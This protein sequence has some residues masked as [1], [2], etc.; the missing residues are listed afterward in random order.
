MWPFNRRQGAKKS[1]PQAETDR[2][3]ELVA[4]YGK[5]I[6]KY[7]IS[8]CDIDFLPSEKS[9]LKKALKSVWAVSDSATR[10]HLGATY[11]LLFQFQ[12]GVGDQPIHS[13]IS[14]LD[15]SDP[16]QLVEALEPFLNWSQTTQNEQDEL[17]AEW[18]DFETRAAEEG[19]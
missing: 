3:F 14:G 6:E 11:V 9:E 8:F 17:L 1:K 15:H 16:L 4:A 18:R 7:P 19:L 13:D 5:I 2:A 10:S 12:L